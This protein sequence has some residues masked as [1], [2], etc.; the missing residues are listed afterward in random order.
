MYRSSKLVV[1]RPVFEKSSLCWT[2][3]FRRL[4][5]FTRGKRDSVYKIFVVCGIRGY[6]RSGNK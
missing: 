1:G 4:S 2:H 6:G 3:L 5:T